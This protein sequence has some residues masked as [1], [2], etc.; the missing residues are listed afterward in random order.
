MKLLKVFMKPFRTF[1]RPKGMGKLSVL[2]GS[3][4]KIIVFFRDFRSC[5]LQCINFALRGLLNNTYKATHV[6]DRLS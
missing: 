4:E 6:A 2:K 1:F 5:M 3:A